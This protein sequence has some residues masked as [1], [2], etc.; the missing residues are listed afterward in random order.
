VKWFRISLG[1]ESA[2]LPRRADA[3][4]G[5]G[6]ARYLNVFK[7]RA[8]QYRRRK[9][10]ALMLIVGLVFACAVL[11]QSSVGNFIGV[12]GLVALLACWV[13]AVLVVLFGLRLKCPAC[14]KPLMPATGPYCP[15]CGSEAYEQGR[16][17]R[18]TPPSRYAF[19]P[20][21]NSAISDGDGDQPRTYRIRGCT[22][23]GVMLDETGV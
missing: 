2:P 19:C 11:A 13:C 20:F 9:H 12:W 21:C 23:C 10:I 1:V 17:V 3:F 8:R 6:R 4:S 16:H 15:N 14:E 22:H 7:P 18:G 5:A